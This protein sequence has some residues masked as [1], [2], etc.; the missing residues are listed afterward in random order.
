MD[1]DEELDFEA[2]DDEDE[3]DLRGILG[4]FSLILMI[5]Y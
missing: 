5:S 3:L 4:N 1:D 2:E